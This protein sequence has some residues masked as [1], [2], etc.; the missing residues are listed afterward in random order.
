LVQIPEAQFGAGSD[1]GLEGSV[2]GGGVNRSAAHK[3]DGVG[4]G[5]A[6]QI[7]TGLEAGG[8]RNFI[9]FVAVAPGLEALD[10]NAPVDG[11][12]AVV[13]LVVGAGGAEEGGEAVDVEAEVVGGETDRAFGGVAFGKVGAKGGVA[14]EGVAAQE[15][16][17]VLG[18]H[19]AGHLGSVLGEFLGAETAGEAE[20]YGFGKLAELLLLGRGEGV[21]AAFGEAARRGDV[22]VFAGVDGVAQG[23]AAVAVVVDLSEG[24]EFGRFVVGFDVDGAFGGN[25]ERTD[26]VFVFW[27][28]L[29]VRADAGDARG[30]GAEVVVRGV[31]GRGGGVGVKVGGDE[32][33]EAA[34][35]SAGWRR[36]LSRLPRD[37][38]KP[39]RTSAQKS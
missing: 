12:F 31:M 20:V 29:D 13:G 10:G 2:A 39:P 15:F 17:L 6:E 34:V 36:R 32:L 25:E 5:F 27:D 33:V 8:C 30:A 19:D 35:A 1:E 11:L 16:G 4:G 37:A 26:A 9:H 3:S 7:V 24:D 23:G 18:E 22:G 28:V 21:E 38:A 14:E